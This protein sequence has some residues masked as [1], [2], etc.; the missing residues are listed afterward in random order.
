MQEAAESYLVKLLADASKLSAHTGRQ[1]TQAE[2]V[3][4]VKNLREENF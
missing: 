1:T 4:F 2:D 3:C